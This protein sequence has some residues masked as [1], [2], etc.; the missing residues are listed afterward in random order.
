[1]AGGGWTA[2]GDN[3]GSLMGL[4]VDIT[5]LDVFSQAV[6]SPAW[7][8]GIGL[9]VGWY[10]W[11]VRR[12]AAAGREWPVARKAC[13]T[14]AAVALL[15]AEISGLAAY[16]DTNFTV[17]SIQHVLIGMVAPICLAL[18]A[19]V[20]LALQAGGAR[21]RTVV[22]RVVEGRAVRVLVHP[23]V[24]WPI[25]GGS[26]FVLYL[27][28]LYAYTLHHDVVRQL[29]NLETLVAGCLFFWPPL[30]VDRVG[31]P[32]GYWPRMLYL[33]LLLPCHTILGMTL[34]SQTSRIARG[35]G[36]ADLHTGGGLLWVAGEAAGLL[37]TI[38]VFVGWARRD[39]QA[40]QSRDQLEE[41]S[42]AA[43]LAHWRATRE[44]AARA[45]S[46]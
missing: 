26:L 18:S 28:P 27:S 16:G 32:L 24:T 42:A 13:F 6:F 3:L 25:Y 36:V 38:A 23:A 45:A 12:L 10:F 43:A 11:S 19:P 29:V 33:I 4:A 20:T 44:A 14:Y 21:V 17:G 31:R 41:T 30:A 9:G 46:R 8:V 37:G 40:A 2:R 22:A 5:P 1:V 15:V 34:E 35:I 7:L 39:L